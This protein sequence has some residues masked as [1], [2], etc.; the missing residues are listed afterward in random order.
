MSYQNVM[1]SGTYISKNLTQS[2]MALLRLMDEH[3]IEIFSLDDIK[4]IAGDTSLKSTRPLK[5]WYKKIFSL[6]SNEG[7]TA[8]Q[9]LGMRKRLDVSWF[10]MAQ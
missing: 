5:I 3:E 4:K 7:N 10:L 2:Q 8:V 6:E 9:I 1:A